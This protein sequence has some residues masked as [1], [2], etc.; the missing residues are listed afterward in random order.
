MEAAITLFGTHG[1]RGCS[2]AQISQHAGIVQSGLHHHFGSKENLLHEVLREY[3]PLSSTRPNILAI[4]EGRAS[5]SDEVR[6]LAQVNYERPDLVRFFA[7]MS[8]ESLT[9]G[10]PARSYFVERYQKLRTDLSE[11]LL[12]ATGLPANGPEA[13][14]VEYL[15]EITIGGLDGL[16]SQWLRDGSIPFVAASA[17]LGTMIEAEVQALQRKLSRA[18]HRN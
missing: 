1:Y 12:A 10:H 2:I 18:E 15:V 4:R 16:Q 17:H 6:K 13:A 5:F 8:G 11:A 14:T 9:E 3:Y 7:V